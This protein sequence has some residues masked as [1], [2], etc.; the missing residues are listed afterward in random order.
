MELRSVH[1]FQ[2]ICEEGSFRAAADKLGVAQPTLS[3]AIG[4]LEDETGAL[5][6]DRSR[7][8]VSLTVYGRSFLRHA[9]AVAAS[10]ADV[11]NEIEAL[12]R[13]TTGTVSV[14]VGPSWIT[15]GLAEAI[16]RLRAEH[17][18]VHL[19]ILRGMDDGLKTLLRSGELDLALAVLPDTTVE[20]DL[21]GEPMTQDRYGIIACDTHPLQG[22]PVRLPDLLEYPWLLSNREATITKRLRNIF[23][24]EGLE[25]PAPA[26][27]C[28]IHAI[29]FALLR[30]SRYLCVQ[31]LDHFH[32]MGVAGISPLD[33]DQTAWSRTAGLIT[34]RSG[35]P[36][37]SAVH[38]IK[39][40]RECC[41][42]SNWESMTE[43]EARL[44]SDRTPQSGR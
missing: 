4:R 9:K 15:Q 30:Y 25:L 11:R 39:L 12:R 21:V 20:T 35:E 32:S 41:V 16:R 13:G 3:K 5:L 19:K 27:E 44:V 26:I 18:G 17:P 42:T 34:R 40:I 8:G 24:V 22:R 31:A 14:G 37:P 38:L 10:T 36:N 1:Y 2:V 7:R 29:R 43:R 33:V 23:S 6:F 28:D